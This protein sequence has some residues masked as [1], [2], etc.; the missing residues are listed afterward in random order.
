VSCQAG[1]DVDD[2]ID[3]NIAE[4]KVGDV[5]GPGMEKN[6]ERAMRQRNRREMPRIKASVGNQRKD[7]DEKRE[8]TPILAMRPL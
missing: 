5:G 3:R 4:Q 2:E 6:P 7:C 8:Q 1:G